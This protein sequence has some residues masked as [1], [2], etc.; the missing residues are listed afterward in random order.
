[1]KSISYDLAGGQNCLYLFNVACATAQVAIK[2]FADLHFAWMRNFV[3]QGFCR[4]DGARRAVS[5]L[6]SAGVNE[7]TL[8]GMGRVGRAEAFNGCD[9]LA[10]GS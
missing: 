3:K 6:N 1:M 5:A 2:G 8:Q 9:L 10:G 4:Q 7:G